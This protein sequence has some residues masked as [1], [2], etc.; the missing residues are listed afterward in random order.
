VVWFLLTA[1]LGGLRTA[2]QHL[3]AQG[4]APQKADKNRTQNPRFRQMI[5]S[6]GKPVQDTVPK[7]RNRF[8]A[9]NHATAES[10]VVGMFQRN[11]AMI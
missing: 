3:M 7:S 1:D 9:N 4:L 2:S 6:A 11:R 8:S 10:E 5:P